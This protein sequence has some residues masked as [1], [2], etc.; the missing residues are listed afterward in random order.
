MK[1]QMRFPPSQKFLSLICFLMLLCGSVQTPPVWAQV[2]MSGPREEN[3]PFFFLDLASFRGE[4]PK[5]PRLDI[6]LK[7][8]Y[9]ELQFVKVAPDS[10]RAVY[11]VSA[12]ILDED[13]FQV[14]GKIWRDTVLVKGFETTNSRQLFHAGKAGLSLPPGKYRVNVGVM[15]VD[16]RRTSFRK[17]TIIVRDF[18]NSALSVSDVLI[19]DAVGKDSSGNLVPQAQVTAPRQEKTQLFAYIEIY[20]SGPDKEYK[21]SYFLKNPKGDKVFQKEV[22]VRHTGQIT[23]V[24][25]ELPSASLAHGV[26]IIHIDLKG[27]KQTAATEREITLHWIG[28]PASIVDLDQ[29]IEQM[30]YL[31]YFI[32]KDGLKNIQSAPSEKRREAFLKFWQENDPTPGTETNELM[33]EYYRRVNYAN[34]NFRNFREGWKTDMGMVYIVFGAPNE[35]ERNPYNRYTN[36]YEGR[37]VKASEVWIYYNLN[38]Q[39]VFFDEVGYGDFRMVYPLSVDQYLH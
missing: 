7:V 29:A 4:K 21:T 16:T 14:N 2:E 3:I 39:F 33:D 15:D 24:L 32:N 13:D 22:M 12:V 36:L 5:E 27:S 18:S 34:T 26:Y 9:D 8:M 17:T 31:R 35:I 30:R 37:T 10:F 19:A 11:E 1:K 28:I 38:R 20:D 25:L 23:P 6:Y